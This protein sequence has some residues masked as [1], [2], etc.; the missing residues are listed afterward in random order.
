MKFDIAFVAPN[1]AV[2]C[3]II[4][5]SVQLWIIPHLQDKNVFVLVLISKLMSMIV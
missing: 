4:L 2:K 5:H 3:M 1:L